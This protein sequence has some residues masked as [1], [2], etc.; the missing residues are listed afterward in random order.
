MYEIEIKVYWADVIFFFFFFFFCRIEK[1]QLLIVKFQVKNN[2]VQ[3]YRAQGLYV[4]RYVN[5]VLH[6]MKY[7]Q[8]NNQNWESL[9][10]NNIYIC[11]IF[12][13][14]TPVA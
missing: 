8:K 14:C 6:F 10:G 5:G 13:L 1:E 7:M 4:Y 3:Q 9:Q 11:N 2:N 12:E